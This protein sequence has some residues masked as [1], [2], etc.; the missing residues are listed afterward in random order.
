MIR[1]KAG[2]RI[3]CI[4]P[5]T[6]LGIMLAGQA[7]ESLGLQEIVVTSCCEGEHRT[8]SLHYLGLAFDLRL[9]SHKTNA[10]YGFT[11]ETDQ[12]AAARIKRA[13]SGGIANGGAFDVVLERTHIHVEFQP[14]T[15]MNV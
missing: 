5:Q 3:D 10:A 15:A 13:L 12:E 11:A 8:G 7:M 6:V 9:P 14:K 2:V 1:L 4:Q